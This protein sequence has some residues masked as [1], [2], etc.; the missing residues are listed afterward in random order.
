MQGNLILDTK[1][2]QLSEA[3]KRAV[4]WIRDLKTLAWIDIGG[5]LQSPRMV[6]AD[7]ENIL[8]ANSLDEI[9]YFWIGRKMNNVT[10]FSPI[11][12]FPVVGS[13]SSIQIRHKFLENSGKI[14]DAIVESIE[15]DEYFVV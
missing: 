14:L 6:Y 9:L 7:T 8:I 10:E 5:S 3:D 11:G 12:Q 15:G 1:G 13:I 2:R 4:A